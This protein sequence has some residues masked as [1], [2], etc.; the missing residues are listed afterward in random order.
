MSTEFGVAPS[1]FLSEAEG[2]EEDADGDKDRPLR[3]D[4]RLLGRLLGET[5]RAQ[6]GGE[7]FAT[8]EAIRRTAIRF[9]R[10]EDDTARRELEATLRGLSRPGAI[11]TIRAFSYFSHL[12][13][14]AEDRH[15]VRRNRTRAAGGE[16][17]RPGTVAG[18]FAR[19]AE[20][21]VE[22]EAIAAFLRQALVSPVLTAHPT[23]VRRRSTLDREREIA[24]LLAERDRAD[25]L[26]GERGAIDAALARA[27]LTLWQTSILRRSRLGVEDEIVN[28][29]AYFDFTFLEEVPRLYRTVEDQLVAADGPRGAADPPLP[30]FFRMGSWIGGDRDGHPLVDAGTLSSAFDQQSRLAFGH[31]RDALRAL[32]AELS[33][34]ERL[35]SVSAA[36]ARLADDARDDSR[37]RRGEPYRRAI[38]G[39]L[40]RIDATE[41]ALRGAG[42]ADAAPAYDGPDS[43]AADL[44]AIDRSLVANGS[45]ALASG[46][47]RTL[48]HAVD[49]FG[50]HLA[51]IDLRQNADVHERTVAELLA[52]AGVAPAYPALGE[53]E[54]VALLVRELESPRLL[55]S[56]YLSYTAETERELAIA[57]AAA[58]ARARHGPRAVEHYVISQAGAVSDVLEVCVLLKEAGLLRP[59]ER[60]LDLD[61][62]PL[63]ETIG[64][65]E[66]SRSVMD[67]LL[68]L[69]LYRTLL[70]GRGDVQEVMLGY[71][72]SNKDGG[73]LTSRWALHRTEV[74]L[75]A[76]FRERGVRLRL[77]H[78]RGGSVG[79][80]GGPSFD[81]ILAQP[82]GSVGG[83]LRITEQGEVITGKYSN[84][85][86]GRRNLEAL[87]AAVMEAS[88][89][90]RAETPG[91]AEAF[92]V[93]DELSQRARRAYRALVYETDGFVRYFRESTVIGEIAGLNIGSRP[94]SRSNSGAIEDLR[95]IPWVFGWSQCRVML[96]GW[97]GFGTAVS[98][99]LEAH[100]EAGLARL[101]AMARDWPFFRTL[102]SNM[103]MVLA[104]TDM[105]I[106]SRYAGLVTDRALAETIFA[107]IR[108]ERD[109]SVAMLLEVTGAPALLAGNPLLARSIRNRF[110]Y[111]D[112]LNHLQVEL[113]KRHRAGDTDDRVIHGINLTI[114]GIAAG[115]R[116]TG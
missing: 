100:G 115:L 3:E 6:E 28:A 54:R 84:P 104:K 47:L 5:V 59:A 51:T 13:N 41:A 66:A 109:L 16:G 20:A 91:E 64:D 110:P 23:E 72:D 36:V 79:R 45:A 48:R 58:A 18:A 87:L 11:Q 52:A 40:A 21:G 62:V 43:L 14:V 1:D 44:A 70:E 94:A 78:G 93:M 60:A 25:L 29:L 50:F 116:N 96:P 82:P 4:I 56:P 10:E 22:R 107:G 2:P 46:R 77:F 27:V 103:D 42:L 49:A 81:A 102:L 9:H 112:P 83:A 15:H 111:I 30:P 8:I 53:A 85:E 71:S 98:G 76:L 19:L 92:A 75:V 80:G 74:E 26:P 31:Y 68:S 61:V 39:I 7:I 86:L 101:R 32:S 38:H 90:K 57:R 69:P 106:A 37:H 113:L 24:G 12:A 108:R 65:L 67:A 89:L 97:Y 55:A 73:F 63:F 35:V 88:L 99:F 105:A 95:A 114:N 34:D 33:L 17:P